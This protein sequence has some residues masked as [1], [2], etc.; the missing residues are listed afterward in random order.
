MA[1]DDRR[2]KAV[3]LQLLTCLVALVLVNAL[4]AL[5]AT[6]GPQRGLFAGLMLGPISG[7]R[8]AM[9]MHGF[10]TALQLLLPATVLWL[11]PVAA[12][13][14]RPSWSTAAAATFAWFASGYLFCVGLWV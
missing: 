14:R 11:W 3:A 1:N 9:K 12:Y 5:L 13:L 6:R 7:W 4:I 8:G 2:R 10:P